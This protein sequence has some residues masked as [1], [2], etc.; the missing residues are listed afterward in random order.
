MSNLCFGDVRAEA[1]G[2]ARGV[3][4]S[5]EPHVCLG[6]EE[7]TVQGMGRQCIHTEHAHGAWLG[8]AL[9]KR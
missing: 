4:E 8:G 9:G 6:A 1:G 7:E 3:R 2:P 5:A